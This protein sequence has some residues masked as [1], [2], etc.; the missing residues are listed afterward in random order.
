M[1]GRNNEVLFGLTSAD[2]WH[3]T[4][5]NLIAF[6]LYIS[7]RLLNSDTFGN[8]VMSNCS[9]YISVVPAVNAICESLNDLL[10]L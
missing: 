10:K 2:V 7:N 9:P 3:G 4:N 5:S 8:C 6:S 1:F